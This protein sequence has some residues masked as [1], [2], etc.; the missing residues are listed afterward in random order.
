MNILRDAEVDRWMAFS[1][2]SSVGLANR[3]QSPTQPNIRKVSIETGMNETG[4]IA[5]LFRRLV[6]K[7]VLIGV[8]LMTLL[9]F[10]GFN[11]IAFNSAQIFRLA[12]PNCNR[13]LRFVV[14]NDIQVFKS[15]ISLHI[16]INGR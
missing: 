8:I 1:W 15:T 9:P 2:T 5:D 12:K 3:Y 16:N 7:P 6:Y 11:A 14:I 4:R 10:S 13:C